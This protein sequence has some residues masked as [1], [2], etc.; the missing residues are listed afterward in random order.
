MAWV[1]IPSGAVTMGAAALTSRAR[2]AIRSVQLCRALGVVRRE[3]VGPVVRR[4]G[5]QVD[6]VHVDVPGQAVDDVA[7]PVVHPGLAAADQPDA[8]VEPLERRGPP[9]GF[10]YVLRRAAAAV[11]RAAEAPVRD[12]ERFGV[13]VRAPAAGPVGLAAAVAG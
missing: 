2:L 4:T 10:G 9:A 11:H 1:S 6:A 12:A 13:P 5:V 3:D 7:V 8:G